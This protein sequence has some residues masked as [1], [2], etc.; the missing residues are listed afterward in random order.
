[1]IETCSGF[2]LPLLPTDAS[3][4]LLFA[5]GAHYGL[6]EKNRTTKAPEKFPGPILTHNCLETAYYGEVDGKPVFL[7]REV[8]AADLRIAIGTVN[9]HPVSGFT[10]GAKILVPALPA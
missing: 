9:V 4:K 2:L 1:V 5:G 8:D 7:N 10:G 3:F 6:E